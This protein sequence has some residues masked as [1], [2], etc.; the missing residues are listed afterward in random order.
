MPPNR[1]AYSTVINAFAQEGSVEAA[2]RWFSSMTADRVVPNEVTFCSMIKAC[3][4][5]GDADH[6]M[7]WLQSGS[8]SLRIASLQ[9][10]DKLSTENMPQPL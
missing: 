6:A 4:N 1:V 8:W 9:A 5:K 2:E 7:Q 3:A 10:L